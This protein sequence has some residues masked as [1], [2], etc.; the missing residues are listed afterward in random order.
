V[1]VTSSGPSVAPNE[2]HVDAEQLQLGRGVGA[3]EG[4]RATE[5]PV[6]DHLG[7]RVSRGRP[8][9]TPGPP[10]LGALPDRVDVL[11]ARA[12]GLVDH[13]AAPRGT[14]ARPQ[15]WPGR[16]GPHPGREHHH[17][18]ADTPLSANTTWLTRPASLIQ[19]G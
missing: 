5:K 15:C 4:G 19:A 11:I 18:G 3:R 1:N 2:A 7:H 9:R 13:D 10:I 12:A 14:T 17:V 6:G 8:A 16:R